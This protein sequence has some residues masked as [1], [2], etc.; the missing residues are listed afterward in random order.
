M[1]GGTELEKNKKVVTNTIEMGMSR[2]KTRKE[3]RK[4]CG[5]NNNKN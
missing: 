3:E 1:G 2:G 5:G 4:S